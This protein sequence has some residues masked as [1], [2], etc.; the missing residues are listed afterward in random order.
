MAGHSASD[1]ELAR[2]PEPA[3]LVRRFASLAYEAI[4]ITPVLFIAAYLFLTLTQTARTPA[5]HALFQLW[6]LGAGH[7]FRVYCWR[8]SGQTLAMKTWHI[9]VARQDGSAVHA[10]GICALRAGSVE[11][12]AFGAG[13]WWG[14]VDRDH[15]FLHDRLVGSRLLRTTGLKTK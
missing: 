10:R 9:R 14:L 12:S 5:M 13:F 6:L 2:P 11:P 4:L 3:G 1:Q 8:H 15:Q 7:L